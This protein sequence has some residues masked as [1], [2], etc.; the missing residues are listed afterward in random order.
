MTG[1][2]TDE[3]SYQL[4]LEH[5]DTTV[6][7]HLSGEVDH[8]NARELQAALLDGAGTQ[9]LVLDLSNVQYL[10]SAG[11]AVVETLRRTTPVL[12]VVAPDS[13]IRHAIDIVGLHYLVPVHT[14]L[15]TALAEARQLVP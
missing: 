8:D 12:L 14:T 4:Q 11:M 6:V 5:R 15:D 1:P 9:P 13:V 10:D 7:A 2:G 3:P